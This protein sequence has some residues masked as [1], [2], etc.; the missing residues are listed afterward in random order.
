MSFFSNEAAFRARAAARLHQ[1]VPDEADAGARALISDDD[2]NPHLAATPAGVASRPAAVLVPVVGDDDGLQVILTKRSEN[3][4]SHGG[5]VA[6]PGGKI[7]AGDAS[8]LA[9]ALR[10]THEETGI[11]AR[12][13][14]PLGYLDVYQTRT[15]FRIVPVVAML[16]PGFEL[17]PEP[18]EVDDIFTVPLAFLMD[19]ANHQ[20]MSRVWQGAAREFYAMP[21]GD[22]FIWGATAGMLRNLYVR[23]TKGPER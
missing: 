23:M 15:G 2:L 19:P 14:E 4:P 18:G 6:F 22:R 11:R 21:Y 16:R 1:A 3:L 17:V 8:P 13:V 20:R 9:A 12:F 10:E 7:D 5:Q